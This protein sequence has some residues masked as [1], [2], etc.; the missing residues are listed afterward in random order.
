MKKIKINSEQYCREHSAD[1]PE[2]QQKI[3]QAYE[4]GWK[5]ATDFICNLPLDKVFDYLDKYITDKHK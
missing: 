1:Q 2:M 3:K 4:D 5:A